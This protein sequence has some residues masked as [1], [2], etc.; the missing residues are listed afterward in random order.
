[1]PAAQGPFG[2]P[3]PLA[4]FFPLDNCVGHGVVGSEVHF[5]LSPFFE[6]GFYE[7]QAGLKLCV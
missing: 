1:M 5:V 7:A 6:T 2:T 4:S 3:A